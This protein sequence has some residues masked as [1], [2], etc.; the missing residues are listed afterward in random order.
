ME[1][2]G[3]NVALYEQK[4]LWDS[5]HFS[6]QYYRLKVRL[7]RGIIPDGVRTILDVGCGNGAITNELDS[8]YWVVGGDRSN[9]ALS[10]LR[11]RGVQLAAEHLPFKHGSFDLVMSHQ[12][13]EHLPDDVFQQ[14]VPE[15]MRVARRYLVISVPYRDRV[16][17][18]RA[19]CED[20]GCKYH[21]W[22]HVRNF[23]SLSD[24]RRLFPAFTL[25]A[26]AFCGRENEYMTRLA[27]WIS[28][29]IG[30]SWTID[31]SG[32]CLRCGSRAQYRAGYPR[33]A[34]AGLID[35][36]DRLIPKERTFWWVICLFECAE[37]SPG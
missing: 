23:N 10:S 1:Y 36:M 34:I 9:A 16:A 7:I 26:Y 27:L 15:M 20:C 25:R 33:R 18:Q 21:V 29:W 31:P 37:L 13:L 35:R 8:D 22:G 11:I 4:S 12:L 32:V 2:M 19:C 6:D 5:P 28:Q 17:Q 30:G 14:A 24:V 3:D